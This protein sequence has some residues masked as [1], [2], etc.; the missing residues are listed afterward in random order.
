[1]NPKTR[2]STRAASLLTALCML[3]VLPASCNSNEETTQENSTE[4]TI[5]VEQTS[6]GPV[7]SESEPDTGII[8]AAARPEPEDLSDWPGNIHNDRSVWVDYAETDYYVIEKHNFRA[9][10]DLDTGNPLLLESEDRRLVLDGLLIDIG[11]DGSYLQNTLVFSDF[12]RLATYELPD[13][14]TTGQ[15]Q[16]D[17]DLISFAET[18]S[19]VA[20][21]LESGETRLVI[22][23]HLEP[24]GLLSNIDI[25]NTGTE[26]QWI[27][28]VL[29]YV[30]SLQLNPEAKMLFPGNVPDGIR[31][32]SRQIVNRLTVA[33]L[34]TPVIM[35]DSEGTPFN[36][37]YLNEQEKWRTG[38]AL[39][40]ESSLSAFH[41]AATE[42]HLAP[43]DSL[44]V[45]DLMIQFADVRDPYASM[46]DF[47]QK[48]GWLPAKG[49]I[50]DGPLYSAHPAGTMDAGFH[51]GQDLFS[52]ADELQVLS[53]MGIEHIWLLPVF[54]HPGRTD[55]YNPTDM[56][57]IDEKY[58]GDAGA[59]HFGEAAAE[60][61]INVLYD[62]VPHG[63]EPHT[64][65]AQAYPEWCAVDRQGNLQIE[66]DSVSF[67]MADPD[68]QQYLYDLV[69][70]Q[71]H[72]YN[73]S[74]ARIDCGMGGLPNW[75]P[76]PGNRPS[77]SNMSGGIEVAR[78]IREAF[79]DSGVEPLIL[80]ENFYPLP[81]YWPHS[82]LFYD[83]PFYRMLY[84]LN[85]ADHSESEYASR[86]VRYLDAEVRS[87]PEGVLHMR[88]LG[89]H[90]T[91][92]W[93]FDQR[94]PQQIYGTDKARALWTLLSLIDGIPMLYQGDEDPLI[95]GMGYLEESRE[96]FAELFSARKM[97]L[98]SHLSIQYDLTSDPVIAFRRFDDSRERLVLINLSTQS[99]ERDLSEVLANVGLSGSY[100]AE[101][102]YGNAS[103]NGEI[104]SMEP[105]SS[106]ILVLEHMP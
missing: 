92:S 1:M 103:I 9:W 39:S 13:I 56:S 70:D 94:R 69:Q 95:Y 68:Y 83:M 5:P 88:F 47:Y 72:R 14:R 24:D 55:V 37:F 61:G 90:D 51:S 21:T 105:Y 32:L 40:D 59:I 89:N 81:F 87:K 74:G 62:Y 25:I 106:T 53:D 15:K 2:I 35:I 84:T 43:G 34:I 73:L 101:P 44:H 31:T 60:L 54:H 75:N 4:T 41:L 97:W 26:Q 80:S 99:N 66:W 76:A 30:D 65:L 11:I 3:V 7:P 18:E 8:T 93:V 85:R 78:V 79:V 19:G 64:P 52:Y 17:Y 58:G 22:N 33:D 20:V 45:G 12:A 49:G 6:T 82:D 10:F 71:V 46:R 42:A 77:N 104:I 63:P 50:T 100:I 23:Y 38:Y 67:D 86:I 57:V 91:V 48:N 28:G 36:I 16:S 102:V 29:F 27:N 96:F 98:G